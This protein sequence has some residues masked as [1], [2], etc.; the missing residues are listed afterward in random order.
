MACYIIPEYRTRY[1]ANLKRGYPGF[2]MAP[3]FGA[4]AETRRGADEAAHIDY[5]QQAEYL[6]SNAQRR[7]AELACRKMTLLE[8]QDATPIQRL[9]ELERDS[10]EVYE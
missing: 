7:Q 6:R 9:P 5:E 2:R 10:A 8:G 3:S 1:A 4:L